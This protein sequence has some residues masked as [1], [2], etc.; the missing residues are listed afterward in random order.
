MA[1]SGIGDLIFHGTSTFINAVSHTRFTK[2][3]FD[4][5]EARDA[6]GVGFIANRDGSS[7]RDILDKA[8]L[9][10]KN[11]AHRGAVDADGRTGDG[12]G[13]LTTVPRAF[14]L[15]K[16]AEAGVS[17]PD[18]ETFA[19]A[20]IFF[21]AK[22]RDRKECHSIFKTTLKKHGIAEF[23]E[24]EVPA[25]VNVL[26]AKARSNKP[27]IVQ[28]FLSCPKGLERD[29][30]ERLLFLVRKEMDIIAT[31]RSIEGF[32]IPSMSAV[33]IIHKGLFVGDQV[34][35]FY[36]D[37]KDPDFTSPFALFHQRFSTNTFPTWPLAHPFRM[38]AH[39][40]EINT[41]RA[42]R[43][44]MTART[45]ADQPRAWVPEQHAL[46][47]IIIAGKS[48][49]ASFD[50]M[51]EA[52]VQ[53]GRSIL[54][55]VAHMLPEAWQR[56]RD[57][58]PALKA[59]YEYHACICEPWDGPAAVAFTDGSVIGTIVDRNGL[60]P[61]RYKITNRHLF[62]CSEMGCVP[63]APEDVEENGKLSPGK[64]I[65]L[66]LRAGKILK[67]SDIK[68]MLAG[69]KPYG[70][71][72]GSHVVG[73]DEAVAEKK[74]DPYSEPD[75]FPPARLATLQN[76]FGYTK[77]DVDLIIKPM[78]TDG[79]EPIGSMG[80][81]TPLAAFSSKPRPVYSYFKQLFAQVTNPPID[82]LREE[83][84]TSLRMYLGRSG[85]IF[86]ETPE[87][88]RQIRVLTP[89]VGKAVFDAI[90]GREEFPAAF[91][92]ATFR[93]DEGEGALE[94]SVAELC[95]AAERA[96]DAGRC[97][98]VLSDRDVGEAHA[99]IPMLIAVSAVHH[100][101]I[102]V[103]K[104]L[105]VSLLAE[106]GEAR[107][108]HHFACLI[109]FGA[110]VVYPYLALGTVSAFARE[111]GGGDAA[112]REAVARYIHAVEA[113]LLKIMS[114]MGIS[115]LQSYH[116]AQLFEIVGFKE[117]LVNY[118]FHG[119]PAGLTGGISLADIA[120][121]YLSW[122]R[123]A[124]AE[125]ENVLDIGG[126][127]RFR[128]EGEYHGNNPDVVKALHKAVSAS[129]FQAYGDYMRLVNEREPM[130]IRD[131]LRVKK[132]SPVP[133]ESVEP[134]AK[135]V[136][137]FCTPGISYGAISKEAHED[138]AVA[139]N[140]I[141]AK[142]DSGEGGEDEARF[143]VLPGGDS[144]N[145]AIKQVASGRFGVTA[146]YLASARELEIKIAQ[147]AKP[148][149]GGQLPG[150][151]VSPD[152]AR[153]RHSTPGVTLISPPPHHDIYSIEDLSQLI[154]D[155]KRANPTAKVCVKLVSEAGIGTIAAGVAKAHADVILISGHDGGTGASPLGSIKHAG[156]PWELGL[157]E[158]Q[159]MLVL[160]NLR[161]RVT[162]RVD[163]GFKTG[164][165]VVKAALFGA[166]EF[167]FGTAALLAAGCVM[168]RQC[169]LNTCPVGVATQDPV[170]RAKYKGTPERIV[171][172]FMYVAEEVRMILALMGFKKLDDIVGRSDLLEQIEDIRNHKLKGL[173]LKKL[174]AFPYTRGT[175]IRNTLPRNDWTD[176]E[177]FDEPVIE[178]IM[179]I[180]KSGEGEAILDLSVKNTQRSVGTRLSY[181]IVARHGPGGLPRGRVVL[182]LTGTAGQSFGAFANASM[183]FHLEGEA[184]DYVGKG[185]SGAVVSIRPPRQAR[186][187]P[188]DN[189]ICGNTCLYGA[190]SGELFV[191]GRAGERFAVRNSGAMSA[192]EGV[193]DH[194]CEYMTGGLVVILG[195][196]GFNFAAGMTGGTAFVYDPNGE[197]KRKVNPADVVILEA[198][199]DD[200]DGRAAV[201]LIKKHLELTKS[202][203]ATRLLAAWDAERQRFVR[204]VPKEVLARREKAKA[205]G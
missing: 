43:N 187:K 181:E 127:Y 13:V 26:G 122:H 100:H 22:E 111:T 130:T 51:L 90:T 190:T 159:Q 89:I 97:L 158:A 128:R 64:M 92:S 197:L 23:W 161:S 175:P 180:L 9:A 124:F 4:P 46:S 171:N 77:E 184:N 25:D 112:A 62:V 149:E 86:E 84:V 154:Y 81:D 66:D 58:D 74:S 148:G 8:F 189:V 60:R 169:H 168:V 16:A 59:F 12:A 162:L 199:W 139:M 205:T 53:G 65:A 88:A 117:S 191:N 141:G 135:L 5:Q 200:D 41:L 99:P 164:L 134:G 173:N 17:V 166:E 7:S 176:D 129:D 151:K 11:L 167:G 55:A 119:T 52:Y 107:E 85:N 203:L 179:P 61:A 160:N 80:D 172:L 79:K 138:M 144:K 174:T 204:V 69:R 1:V 38:L 140:R 70:E 35:S 47:K 202:P 198:V 33:T 170:L 193:G 15:K 195:G 56:H 98:I 192:V 63:F 163:G 103:G 165:D 93:A 123:R 45:L 18:P 6:C 50:N 132:G 188:E 96:V 102:R 34:Q 106:T 72:V 120:R 2:T 153:V 136:K 185:L 71:W 115:T 42:N 67:D 14:Y 150:H 155:L 156:L 21:P 31:E 32:Y 91:L 78:M 126:Q 37:L 145:S 121:D 3:G 49:S 183:E 147:G 142:S 39:N 44:W 82:P 118:H 194:G 48:D 19:I 40:G 20:M 178:K 177:R 95:V 109:G 54:H 68:A 125:D 75:A 105:L 146:S 10:L 73:I 104:R 113:G 201:S 133:L 143:A 116:A 27:H 196:V 87:H 101:L 157:A 83:I 30:F 76:A 36:F 94:E 137:R 24:R 182:N 114:K 108:V 131:L 186:F 57:F 29:D 28:K 110:S 152:I